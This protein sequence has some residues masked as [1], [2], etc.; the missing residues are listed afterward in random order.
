VVFSG[1]GGQPP[2]PCEKSEIQQVLFNIFKNG[3]EAMAMGGTKAPQFTIRYV[4]ERGMVGVEIRDNGPGF[5]KPL[6]KR[7]FEP[8]FTTKPVGTGTGLGLSV[9]YF[10]IVENHGGELTAASRPGKGAV[11]TVKL[12]TQERIE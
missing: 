2:V 1:G 5:S 12:P 8:F 6:R 4:V 3:A 9:S 10:I 11:F 7:L